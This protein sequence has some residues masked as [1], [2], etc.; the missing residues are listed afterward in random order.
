MDSHSKPG[1]RRAHTV[2]IIPLGMIFTVF[3]PHF[4]LV[5][6]TFLGYFQEIYSLMNE[7]FGSLICAVHWQPYSTIYVNGSLTV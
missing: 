1:K 7:R 5:T 3:L 4:V 6:S 2:I